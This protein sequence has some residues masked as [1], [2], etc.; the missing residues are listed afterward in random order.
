MIARHICC[1][2]FMGLLLVPASAGDTYVQGYTRSNGTYVQPHFRSAPDHNPYNNWSA[3]GNTNPYTG[4]TRTTILTP[5]DRAM[6]T[7]IVPLTPLPILTQNRSNGFAASFTADAAW[8][9]AQTAVASPVY[10]CCRG[11]LMRLLQAALLILALAPLPASAARPRPKP[12]PPPGDTATKTTFPGG[13]SATFDIVYATLPGFAPL[14]LD[15]YVPPARP[16]SRQ[17]PV[18]MPKP[19]VVFVHGGSWKNGD[20]RHNLAFADFPRAL[21]GLAAQGYVVASVNYRLSPQARFPAALQDVKAAIR[22]LRGHAASYGG[23][24]TRVAVWG[25]SAG[26][27]LAAMAGTTCGVMRFEPEGAVSR[28]APSDC[29]EAVIDWF[30]PTDLAALTHAGPPPSDAGDY[31]G[32]EPAA[33]APGALPLASPLSLHIGERAA[34]PDPARR[35]RYRSLAQDNRRRFMTR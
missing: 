2:I 33:C 15:I 7:D 34:L 19:M 13:V 18:P 12:T 6:A 32:C 11:G 5:L 21:A 4:V 28:D 20:S 31:L 25:A 29:A 30:G 22:W 3:L 1:A 27:H 17:M 14:T 9:N 10:W 24:M 35:R 16:A 8:A 26:A 23:D